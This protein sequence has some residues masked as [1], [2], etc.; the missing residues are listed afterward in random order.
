MATCVA[1]AAAAAAMAAKAPDDGSSGTKTA[2]PATA[3]SRTRIHSRGVL[4]DAEPDR[5]GHQ[6]AA[7]AHAFSHPHRR[8]QAGADGRLR[9]RLRAQWRVQGDVLL[10]GWTE[11]RKR[12]WASA[13]PSG[14]PPPLVHG[15][16]GDHGGDGAARGPAGGLSHLLPHSSL[17]RPS[18]GRCLPSPDGL[19]R[20]RSI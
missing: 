2:S 6:R 20:P 11:D 15:R 10:A 9:H 14:A 12:R 7:D 8:V 13:L 19:W 18:G 17:N 4:R 16:L 1:A 3:D 5:R